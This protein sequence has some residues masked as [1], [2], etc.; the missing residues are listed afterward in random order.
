M[1][2]QLAES[3]LEASSTP[4]LD[5]LQVLRAGRP[6]FMER[7]TATCPVG[8]VGE[9]LLSVTV[10]VQVIAW[11][12]VSGLGLQETEVLV[13]SFPLP[14]VDNTNVPELP[15]LFV[16]PPYEAVIVAPPPWEGV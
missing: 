1:T 13:L 14:L 16:S 9:E 7:R 5:R 3:P 15:A 11:W 6:E 8:V 4:T 2:V 10:I 12:T